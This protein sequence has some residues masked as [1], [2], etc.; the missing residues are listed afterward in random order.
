MTLEQIDLFEKV[1][2]QL[3]SLHEEIS[4]LSKK[5]QNDALNKFKLKFVNQTIKEANNLLGEE[6]K[7]F[8]EFDCF[9][10]ED[11]PTNSDVT[12]ILGQ[13]L[14]CMEKLRTDNISYSNFQWIWFAEGKPTN[15]KTSRPKKLKE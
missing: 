7:P 3:I 5:S 14:T 12:M 6:Y 9:I 4:A 1:N 2:N 8:G 13:Y 10:E 11:L 15:I